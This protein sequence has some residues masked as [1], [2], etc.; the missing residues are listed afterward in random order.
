MYKHFILTRFNLKMPD[1]YHKD[2]FGNSTQDEEW[3]ENRFELFEKYCFPS[4][5]NQTCKDFIWLVLFD[6]DTPKKY[7]NKIK[8]YQQLFSNFTP[9]FL[10]TQDDFHAYIPKYLDKN[11]THIITTRIDNDDAFNKDM[12][13]EVQKVFDYQN[14]VIINFECG[15]EYDIREKIAFNIFVKNS[16]FIGRIELFNDK[17]GV[18]TTL[19]VD[20]RYIEKYAEVINITNK[21]RMW[22]EVIH[23]KNIANRIQL[24]LRIKPVIKN[25]VSDFN[26]QISINIKNLIKAYLVHLMK[27]IKTLIVTLVKK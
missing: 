20:H 21:K 9:L 5:Q 7:L 8:T 4:I 10:K 12:I 25:N 2:K 3:L 26:F 17:D 1:S 11:T 14:D 24:Y 23:S 27:K 18:K 16:H 19:S 22:V 13:S 6:I 15:I